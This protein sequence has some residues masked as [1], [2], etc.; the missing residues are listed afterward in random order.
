MRLKKPLIKANDADVKAFAAKT[1]P[2]LK[3]HLEMAEQTEKKTDK[4]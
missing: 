3:K 4:L 2:T 1:I